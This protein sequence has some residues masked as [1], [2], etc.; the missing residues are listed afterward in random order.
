ME[1]KEK[2][3]IL[4]AQNGDHYAFEL[5]VS[6]YDRQVLNLAYSIVGNI[7]DAQDIYQ[8][9]LISAYKALPKFRFKSN[10]FTW[11]YRIAVNKSIT[12]KRKK[13]KLNTVSISQD[14][15]NTVS[16]DQDIRI[17]HT[18]TPEESSLQSE[19]RDEIENAILNLSVKER[20]AFVL[21]HQQGHKIRE[22]AELMDCT[23]GTV[24]SYLF[25]GREKLKLQLK[26]YMES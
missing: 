23:L 14:N 3:L 26:T 7:E 6:N 21:C 20:M 1:N 15:E 17:S 9:A 2:A 8:E 24:K 5:L 13:L 11:I 4:R 10:F 19:M 18:D 25:R 16:V 22:A 12:F